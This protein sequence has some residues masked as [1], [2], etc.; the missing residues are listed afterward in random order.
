MQPIVSN[1]PLDA[2]GRSIY[3][4]GT[5]AKKGVYQFDAAAKQKYLEQLKD[6]GALQRSAYAVGFDPSTVHEHRT[7]DPEFDQAVEGAL[8]DYQESIEAEIKRRAMDGIEQPVFYQGVATSSQTVYSDQLLALHAKARIPRYRDKQ[9]IDHNVK[10]G[11]LVVPG[12]AA[13][14]EEWEKDG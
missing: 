7:L 2:A 8:V 3:V 6:C 5:M 1:F 12:L 10:G 4:T 11:I 13:T 9:T 14:S